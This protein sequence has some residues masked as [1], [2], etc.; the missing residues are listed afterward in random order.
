[1]LID[2]FFCFPQSISQA[3]ATVA[4]LLAD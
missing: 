4:L 3:H 2:L 1:M